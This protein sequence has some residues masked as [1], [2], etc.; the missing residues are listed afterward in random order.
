MLRLHDEAHL[1]QR[2]EMAIVHKGAVRIAEDTKLSDSPGSAISDG[3]GL[4]L[5]RVDARHECQI[6]AQHINH[7]GCEHKNQCDPK[8]PVM[9]RTFPVGMMYMMAL[10]Q[11][12]SDI[13][14]R[15]HFNG[16]SEGCR[17]QCYRKWLGAI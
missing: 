14:I 5:A 13:H 12:F 15:L 10:I 4:H 3:A 11:F 6:I 1:E 17:Q 2:R 16:Q 8:L 7:H 9:M